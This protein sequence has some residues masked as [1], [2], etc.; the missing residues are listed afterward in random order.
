VYLLNYLS[1]QAAQQLFI[2][3]GRF[4]TG[5]SLVGVRDGVNCAFRTPG[6]EKFTQNL[7]YITIAVYF[8]GIRQVLLDDFI[9]A[10]S[11]GPGTGYDT[12]IF[13]RPPRA[14]DQIISDYITLG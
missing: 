12:V 2:A 3:I 4:R 6:S 1:M 5:T 11:A 9:L 14:N 10:E 7:P 8:N 13:E